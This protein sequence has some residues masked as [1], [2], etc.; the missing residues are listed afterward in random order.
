MGLERLHKAA[1]ADTKYGNFIAGLTLKDA[2]KNATP[3]IIDLIRAVEIQIN[4]QNYRDYLS[5][6]LEMRD[7]LAA[8]D[9]AMAQDAGSE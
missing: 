7:A 4:P 8:L 5:S 1:T 3:A 9:R 2:L 6:Y